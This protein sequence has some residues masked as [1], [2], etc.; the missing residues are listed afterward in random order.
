MD[1]TVV[2]VGGSLAADPQKLRAL[3]Q[4]LCELSEG[5]RLVVV[6]GGAEFADTVRQLDKKFALSKVASHRMAVLAMDQYGLLLADL[7][8]NSVLVRDL[9]GEVDGAI[10]QGKLPIFLPSNLFFK[11]DPLENSWDVTSDSIALYL[12]AQLGADR[13]LFV[14]DVD[15]VYTSNPK[16]DK[17]AKLIEK[18]SPAELSA[19]GRT[20]VDKALPKLLLQYKID[21]Y[22]INGHHPKRIEA[23]LMKQKT[24]CT[25]ISS[26]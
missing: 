2:K 24:V 21:C 13:V 20:S 26:R 17:N 10:E 19:L 7:V 1:L 5:H 16:V 18:L 14:T 8:P 6:P 12:A 4:K 15:G 25:L 3:C 22:V 9:G 23:V 11:E